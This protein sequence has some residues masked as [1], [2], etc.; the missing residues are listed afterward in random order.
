MLPS[1]VKRVFLTGGAG[2]IGSHVLDL[3][4]ATGIAFTVYDDLSNGKLAFIE[5]HLKRPNVTFIQADILDAERLVKEMPGHD[6]VWH[7]AANTDIIGS[8]A[9]P[10]NDLEAGA[11]GTFNVL[12]AMRLTG[13]RDLLFASSGAVYGNICYDNSVDETAGP[14]LP[15]SSYGAGKLAA[16]SF[17]AAH[18]SVYDLR[19]WMF[20]FGNVLGARMTHGVIFDFVGRL[21]TEPERLLVR[22][23]GKQEKNYFLVE[24]C[25]DGMAYAYRSI[26]MTDDKP[27]DVFNLGTPSVTRVT[28]IARIV[29]DEMGLNNARIEIE[30]TK[31]AWPGDQP[32]VHFSV[33]KMS[34]L[35]WRSRL[36]SDASVRIAIK[37]QL[38]KPDAMAFVL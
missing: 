22:G 37:R 38:G 14:L 19:A 9:R 31:R 29:V 35:G 13:V 7:L 30:G 34:K 10:G 18:C 2:F 16:E 25:I 4:A 3:L 11:I 28:D 33:D 26:P 20:R 24:E 21:K 12:E 1:H 6:L 36:N 23:D 27:C 15:V 32:R 17:I 5:Q 8:H